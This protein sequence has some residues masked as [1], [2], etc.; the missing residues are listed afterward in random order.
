MSSEQKKAMIRQRFN[1]RVGPP[2]NP[3]PHRG[4]PSLRTKT[5][6]CSTGCTLRT[7]TITTKAPDTVT[8]GAVTKPIDLDGSQR[9]RLRP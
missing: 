8:L 3:R 1:D 6:T 5:P 4:G 7:R 2:R 9:I